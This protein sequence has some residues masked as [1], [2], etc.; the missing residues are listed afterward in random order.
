MTGVIKNGTASRNIEFINKLD[1]SRNSGRQ[2][3]HN[4]LSGWQGVTAAAKKAVTELDHLMLFITPKMIESIL[5]YTNVRINKLIESLS[6]ELKES[7]KY[8]FLKPLDIEEFIAFLGLCYYRDLW[9]QNKMKVSLLYRES[10]PPIFSATMS[11][12]R[13]TFIMKNRT[14]DNQDTWEGRWKEDRDAAFRESFECLNNQ[15]MRMVVPSDYLSLDETLNPMRTQVAF[16][17][18]NPS[19]PAKYGML[20]KSTNDA[21]YPYT[22]VA[23]PYCVKPEDEDGPYY[24]K[25]TE[26]I[27]R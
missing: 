25:G 8:P 9:Q 21:T 26:P 1:N 24:I 19:K 18:F 12:D 23:S 4:L 20:F 16:R 2:A 3:S 27:V 10:G 17:Q 5:H 14:F 15:C 11:R 13:F 22:F 6:D 7:G